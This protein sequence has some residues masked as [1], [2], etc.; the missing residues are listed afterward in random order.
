MVAARKVSA[1]VVGEVVEGVADFFDDFCGKVLLYGIERPQFN[2]HI[3]QT[4]NK[5]CLSLTGVCVV[6]LFVGIGIGI[7]HRVNSDSNESN[8][9]NGNSTEY[10]A[11]DDDYVDIGEKSVHSASVIGD[12]PTIRQ[13]TRELAL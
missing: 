6:L 4:V 2:D 10:D 3:M 11:F 13:E 8:E 12:V 1:S 9:S 5:V 7:G